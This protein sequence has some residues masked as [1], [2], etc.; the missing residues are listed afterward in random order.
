MFICRC[1]CGNRS[2][3]SGSV[4]KAGR[5]KSCR[6]CGRERTLKAVSTHGMR[7]NPL[8]RIWISMK[9]RCTNPK[10]PTYIY[11]GARG[12]TVCDRWMKKFEDFYED[13]GA[14]PDGMQL[15]RIDNNKGYY[16][17]NCR[18]V[19]P[20]ENMNNRRGCATCN[21]RCGIERRNNI[22]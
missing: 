7:Y 13:V 4:L 16:K 21:C 18:W 1:S 12:I 14:R 20:R 8:Y 19:T 3:C 5:I 17:E 15:D 11:Y 6:K 22:S 2:V 10:S 9:T